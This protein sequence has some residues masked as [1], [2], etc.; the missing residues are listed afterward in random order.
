[1][2]TYNM[3]KQEYDLMNDEYYLE[4]LGFRLPEEVAVFLFNLG[5]VED[6]TLEK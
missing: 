1:M 2:K 5:I 3:L 4:F 6:T